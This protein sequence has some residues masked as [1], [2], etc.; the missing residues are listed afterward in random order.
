VGLFAAISGY[1]VDYL[2]QT[3]NF[4]LYAILV[5]SV[6]WIVGRMLRGDPG[7]AWGKHTLGPK[8]SMAIAGLATGLA[9]LSRDDGVLLV[10]VVGLAWLFERLSAHQHRRV[11]LITFG[12]ILV[13]GLV[14]LLAVAPWLIRQ[15]L[16]FGTLSPSAS[17]G[18]ILW[19]RT[20]SELF[21]ADGPIGMGYLLSW[22]WQNLLA[23]R[24]SALAAVFELT[25]TNL[26]FVFGLLWVAFG[27]PGNWRRP[28]L[29]PYFLWGLVFGAWSVLVAAPHLLAG[30]FL[31]SAVA[32]T[33][34]LYLLLVDGI[35]SFA[36]R[37]PSLPYCRRLSS[38]GLLHKAIIGSLSLALL[39][40]GVFAFLIAGSWSSYRAGYVSALAAVQ[41][42]GGEGQV[43]MAADP[44]LIWDIDHAMPAI[45]TPTSDLAVV[46]QAARSYGAHWLILD[47]NNV[48]SA[49]KPILTGDLHPDWLSVLPIYQSAPDAKTG[50]SRIEV[51]E[52][53]DLPS[54][55]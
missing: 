3:D 4:A 30:N 1:I 2:S 8:A 11:P 55:R 54:A 6:L 16:V 52:I 41:S 38:S 43:V 25:A 40:S 33:P 22:G 24:L 36:A 42:Y 27:L 13:Y 45:A 5:V 35:H 23:S 21:S 37:L 31:H 18:R 44:G 32:L 49:L 19:I 20:Y 12:A 50:L 14:A 28:D 53:V 10:V 51:Y 29:R 39:F 34:L 7:V 48:V 9:F 15:E 46:E 17:S 26:L 47:R